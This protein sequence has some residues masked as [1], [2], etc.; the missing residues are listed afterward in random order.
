MNMSKL[1]D[2]VEQVQETPTPRCWESIA[3]QL[4]AAGTAAGGTTATAATK[5]TIAAGKL[6]AIIGSAAAVVTVVT[7]TTV[8]LLKNDSVTE[9]QLTA[10]NP[11]QII[12]SDSI[13]TDDTETFLVESESATQKTN[14][15]NSPAEKSNNR[16]KTAEINS[17]NP[18]NTA[19]L[20]P[21]PSNTITTH[22]TAAITSV[23]NP[24]ST[25]SPNPASSTQTTQAQNN[26]ASSN[27][28][29]R[30]I[31]KTE[32]NTNSAAE[33]HPETSINPEDF[34]YS[35]PVVIEIPNIFTP[36][37]DG[38]NERFVINGLDKC[39]KRILVVKN[40]KGETVFQSNHYDNSWDGA[41]LSDGS[42]YYQFMY[43][44][45]NINEVRKGV[46]LIRR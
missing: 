38:V 9:N 39:D 2:I 18:A 5:G 22:P 46:V 21:T 20:A 40:Q 35:H 29:P 31:E 3:S 36:N 41:N 16:K 33:S 25:P 30:P 24:T 10:D 44:I 14:Q 34:G 8:S 4:P 13:S 32:D 42:Y 15:S 19:E 1:K 11:T 6:A 7:V 43:S 12:I 45:N 17:S 23:T 27:P 26:T 37:G 28:Q